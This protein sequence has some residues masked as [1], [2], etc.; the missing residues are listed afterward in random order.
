MGKTESPALALCSF[1]SG[2]AHHRQAR[3]ERQGEVPKKGTNLR[4]K[5]SLVDHHQVRRHDLSLSLSKGLDHS[6]EALV[7]ERVEHRACPPIH[8]GI[9]MTLLQRRTSVK[10]QEIPVSQ[11]PLGASCRFLLVHLV[12]LT[13]SSTT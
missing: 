3:Q 2:L 9:H 4:E 7:D 12:M 13:I 6:P 1:L 11:V 5:S 8:P 10:S